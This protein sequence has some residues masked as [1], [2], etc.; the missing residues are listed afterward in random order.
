MRKLYFLI[1]FI[2]LAPFIATAQWHPVQHASGPQFDPVSGITVTVTKIGSPTGGIV[3]CGET[4]YYNIGNNQANG[5][6]Y[7]FSS[8]AK[9]VKIR[10]SE[11]GAGELIKITVN[12]I[13]YMVTNTS[14]TTFAG[15]C[16]P[17]VPVANGNGEITTSATRADG[18]IIIQ[19]SGG[20]DSIRINHLNGL[21]SGTFYDLAYTLDTPLVFKHPFTDTLL[22]AGDAFILDYIINSNFGAGNTLTVQLSNA[23][24][25]FTTGAVNIGTKN[26]NVTGTIA[27]TIPA[28]TP[29]GTNYRLRIKSTSPTF[30]TYLPV[31]IRIDRFALPP[32]ASLDN[33]SFCEGDTLNLSTKYYTPGMNIKW[34]GPAG[35]SKTTANPELPGLQLENTGDYFFEASIGACKALDTV[36]VAV[37]L[38]PPIQSIS[39]N[40]PLCEKDTLRIILD[41]TVGLPITYEWFGPNG[42]Y[43]TVKNPVINDVTDLYTGKFYLESKLGFCIS[44]DNTDV[45]IRTKPKI[46]EISNN[47]PVFP[48]TELILNGYSPTP[49]VSYSWTGPDGFTSTESNPRIQYTPTDAA[50]VYNLMVT[51]GICTTYAFTVVDVTKPEK[52]ILQVYPNIV[53]TDITIKGITLNEQT[54]TYVLANLS[55]NILHEGKIN[56]SRKLVNDTI[57][58]PGYLSNGQYYLKVRVDG[59]F[60]VYPITI[61]K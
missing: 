41:D 38:N 48:G 47:G 43:D 55:G 21:T 17:Q 27:C 32:Y 12:G 54:I 18:Q 22:C 52:T 25:S 9:Q 10:M 33:D 59:S 37:F 34:D 35:F 20:I 53:R 58:L 2:C 13:Q 30:T 23:A 44:Y 42:F 57:T 31:D 24:G 61:L 49:G 8:T 11:I 1:F 16:T 19:Q 5:Y 29:S 45:D 60:K 7:A 28:I 39:N 14:L 40:S 56:T 15:A 4:F 50:G 6:K 36:S 3:Q 51:L 26:S 46:P